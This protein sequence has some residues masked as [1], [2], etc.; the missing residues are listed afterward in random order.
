MKTFYPDIFQ[1]F[2]FYFHLFWICFCKAIPK[3]QLVCSSGFETNLKHCKCSNCKWCVGS[4]GSGSGKGRNR[5]E[6][7]RQMRLFGFADTYLCSH[8]TTTSRAR[9]PRGFT[10]FI[11]FMWF[12]FIFILTWSWLSCYLLKY[13]VNHLLE[14]FI[15]SA[16]GQVWQN[17][18]LLQGED[19]EGGGWSWAAI[20]WGG[21]LTP[22]THSPFPRPSFPS[23]FFSF[24]RLGYVGRRS[25][26]SLIN[27]E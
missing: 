14:V 3:S 11:L 25:T 10:S 9:L 22:R 26:T 2:D 21:H 1:N 24:L 16:S 18:L 12:I 17:P 5:D 19:V 15:K 7:T 23:S 8:W 13:H 20:R 27:C 6:V 4:D